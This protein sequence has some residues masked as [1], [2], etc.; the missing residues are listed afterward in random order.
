[1][2]RPVDFV[3]IQTA[4]PGDVVLTLPMIRR[5]ARERPGSSIDVVTVPSAA[6]L[7]RNHPDVRS[8]IAFDKRGRDSGAAGLLRTARRLKS[9]G[10]GCAIVPHRSLRS[11]LLA[12]LAGIPDRIGFNTS[13]GRLFWTSTV[14]YDPGMHEI[15]RNLSLLAP[16]GIGTAGIEPPGLHPGAEE[17]AQVDEFLRTRPSGSTRP[18]AAL[19][20]GT[21]WNTKRWPAERF[22]ELASLLTGSGWDVVLVG[23]PDDV[24]LCSGIAAAAGHAGIL[25]ASGRF[26]LLGSAELIGRTRVIV[27]NDS[28]PLHLA[29]AMGVRVVSIFGATVPSFGFGPIGAADMVIETPGLSCRPCAIHGGDRCPIGTFDCMNR[30]EPAR[31]LEAVQH[32]GG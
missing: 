16:L 14:A 19:A 12:R 18:L 22:A 7:L 29:G 25:D 27:C 17:R 15:G 28:A 20:P 3:V 2:P 11:S 23:G 13:A 9:G 21:V 26:S 32:G 5:L 10:Y 4:F 6:G 31:V 1:M 8:V 30:I 24:A